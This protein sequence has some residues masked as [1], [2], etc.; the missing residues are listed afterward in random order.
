M[1]INNVVY[2]NKGI[3]NCSDA[4]HSHHLGI[5]YYVNFLGHLGSNGFQLKGRFGTM[6]IEEIIILGAVLELPAEQHCQ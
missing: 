6:A 2:F 4:A 5:N 1:V 3:D